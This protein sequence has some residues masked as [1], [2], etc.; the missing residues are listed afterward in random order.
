LKYFISRVTTC[1]VRWSKFH[2]CSRICWS[3]V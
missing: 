1:K 3:Y 2:R